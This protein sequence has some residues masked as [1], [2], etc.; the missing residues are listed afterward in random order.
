LPLRCKDRRGIYSSSFPR[1]HAWLLHYHSYPNS[2]ASERPRRVGTLKCPRSSLLLSVQSWLPIACRKEKVLQCRG[3][4]Q[5]PPPPA[6]ALTPQVA[7]SLALHR[8]RTPPPPPPAYTA[9]SAPP[10]RRRVLSPRGLPTA[11]LGACSCWSA[12][13]SIH[14]VRIAAPPKDR[15]Q[16]P[17][18]SCSFYAI[19]SSTQLL[20][21]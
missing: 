16:F 8:I 10:P 20:N 19:L 13:S 14:L 6:G 9:N 17:A 12:G 4:P 3:P 7:T 2:M 5:T 11:N 1:M 18:G 15:Y 21:L